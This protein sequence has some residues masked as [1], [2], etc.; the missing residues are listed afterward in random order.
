MRT[1]G[2]LGE[3]R[4]L[5]KLE[6]LNARIRSAASP[7]VAV[8]VNARWHET[9]VGGC[10]ND[11]L[12]GVLARVRDHVLRYE[13]AYFQ[14]AKGIDSSHAFHARIQE[15]LQRGD[16]QSASEALHDHWLS[17]FEFL[18]TVSGDDDESND[19]SVAGK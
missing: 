19:E 4:T 2:I 15:A 1:S 9:L 5:A 16:I 10:G 18:S 11:F 14:S 12:L 6:A 3:R 8:E 17:D 7:R 13:Y